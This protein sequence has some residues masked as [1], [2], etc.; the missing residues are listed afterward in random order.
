M[1]DLDFREFYS[2]SFS[3][4][5]AAVRAYCADA[6]VAHEA[7]QEAFARAF[8]RWKRVRLMSS[9]EAWV[10]TTAFNVGRR[11]FKR[12]RPTVDREGRVEGPT[13][14]RIDLLTI[15][16]RM[17]ARQ[18]QAIVLHYLMD[19][20]VLTVAE[21]MGLSEGTVKNHLHKGRAALRR[22]LE[23]KHV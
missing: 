1:S 6:D 7:T 12:R 21:L 10:T 14:D 17:P 22:A 13:A 8:A 20:P 18:R 5:N 2:V 3:R 9:P 23:V 19:C 15:L 16:R 11:H 4:V